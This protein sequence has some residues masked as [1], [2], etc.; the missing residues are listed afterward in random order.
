LSGKAFLWDDYTGY[1]ST[2]DLDLMISRNI[3]GGTGDPH[4]ALYNDGANGDLAKLDMKVLYN[5]HPTVR[6]DQ[7]ELK[8]TTPELWVSFPKPL[9]RFWFR[10]KIQFSPGFTTDGITPNYGKGYKL[11]G[12]GW[13][14]NYGRG[15]IELGSINQYYIVWGVTPAGTNTAHGNSP[16]VTAS[17]PASAEWHGDNTYHNW[18]DYIVLYEQTSPTTVRERW[19]LA[20][21]GQTPVL[22]GDNVGHMTTGEVP[23][24]DRFMLGMNFNQQRAKGQNQSLW[25]GQWELV[26][27][28]QYLNPFGLPGF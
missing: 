28:E 24:A 14:G 26:D 10:A 7:P 22:Q 19:W 17:R 3:A 23:P 1:R 18:Y 25:Y 5:G 15:S 4:T 11:F 9:R 20:P 16:D 13:R 21:D 8:N 12:W 6:Y 27:G 2:A